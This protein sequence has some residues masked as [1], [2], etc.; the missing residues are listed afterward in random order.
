MDLMSTE[1]VESTQGSTEAEGTVTTA[2]ET[3][4][5]PVKS[6]RGRKR[7][8]ETLDRDAQAYAL[9]EAAGPQGLTRDELAFKLSEGKD[10]R[11]I[12]TTNSAYLSLNRLNTQGKLAKVR[13][14]GKAVWVTKENEGPAIAAQAAAEADMLAERAAAAAEAAQKAAE[15]ARASQEAATKAKQLASQFQPVEA[16]D[17]G[18][19][20]SDEALSYDET[21]GVPEPSLQ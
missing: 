10:L 20:D 13:R 3:S 1:T 18:A 7:S 14:S 4:E 5:T 19:S 2:T 17:N 21:F 8:A 16:S 9:L 15:V 12:V 6:G 11:D